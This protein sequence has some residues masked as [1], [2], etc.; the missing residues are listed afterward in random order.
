MDN[1]KQALIGK[2]RA[3][4]LSQPNLNDMCE[5]VNDISG[6]EVVWIDREDLL[7]ALAEL[8]KS[9]LITEEN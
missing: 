7:T 8:E 5:T 1:S 4:I 3:L 2:V 6:E 9:E